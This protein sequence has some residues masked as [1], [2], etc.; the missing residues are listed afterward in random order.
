MMS[1][2]K[3]S[4]KALKADNEPYILDLGLSEEAASEHK[5]FARTASE[6]WGKHTFSWTQ[7]F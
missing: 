3:P 4:Y 2:S 5:N 6:T 7:N 1:M